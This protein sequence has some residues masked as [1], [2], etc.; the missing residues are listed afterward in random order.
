MSH[1]DKA[2]I[3]QLKVQG[4]DKVEVGE[5]K[6]GIIKEN[7]GIPGLAWKIIVMK[8]VIQRILMNLR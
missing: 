5:M 1:K 6:I 3:S 8:R 4:M 7:I 2:V